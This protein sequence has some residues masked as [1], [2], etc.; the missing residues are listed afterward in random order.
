MSEKKQHFEQK[1]GMR[2]SLSAQTLRLMQLME[3]SNQRLEAEIE[4]ELVENPALEIDDGTGD[5]LP[6]FSDDDIRQIDREQDEDVVLPLTDAPDEQLVCDETDFEDFFPTDDYEDFPRQDEQY[7]NQELGRA[8]IVSNTGIG[9]T[10][11]TENISLQESLCQQLL[12]EDLSGRDRKI[13]EYIVGNIDD[14]GRLLQDNR[15]LSGDLLLTYNIEV[16]PEDIEQLIVQRIQTLDPPGVGARD[17]R[18]CL[19]LQLK[20]LPLSTPVQTAIDIISR[21]FEYFSKKKYDKIIDILKLTETEFREAIEIILKLTPRITTETRSRWDQNADY[22]TPDFIVTIEDGKICLTLNT[23]YLPTLKINPSFQQ[24]LQPSRA[25][26]REPK[27]ATV[28]VR[29]NLR[30]ATRFIEA[31]S[32]REKTLYNIAKHIVLKQQDYFLTGDEQNINPMVLKDIAQEVG[33]DISTVSRVVSNKYMQTPFGIIRLRD[34]F[35]ESVG[36]PE[37]SS[38]EIKSLIWEM[39]T[40]EDKHAPLTDEDICSRLSKHG[41]IVARRTVSKYRENLGILNAKLR[42]EW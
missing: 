27:A 24:S 23:Q 20:R 29:D 2:Q 37:T 34:L 40:T 15:T 13:V 42:K 17:L 5:E 6:L 21:A 7:M 12:G 9:E 25:K 33:V 4:R 32:Q 19:L 18:E 35:S 22:L 39:I 41:Y 1:Q 31:L 16:S 38:K 8:S 30:E 36:A 3:M 14:A 10:A 11:V 26:G 28:Y